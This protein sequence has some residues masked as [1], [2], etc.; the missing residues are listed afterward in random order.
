MPV[1][2][3][4]KP[5]LT[6]KLIGFSDAE[7][8]KFE[9]ILTLAE[10]KLNTPWKLT[11]ATEP[12]FYLISNNLRPQINKDNFLESLPRQQCIFYTGNK[13]DSQ[14]Y[15]IL[16]G[17]DNI[18][19]L[20]SLVEVLNSISSSN[21]QQNEISP[22]YSEI[23]DQ[24]SQKS[25]QQAESNYF[26]PEQGFIGLLLSKHEHIQEYKLIDSVSV[27]KL[28]VDSKNNN[29]YCKYTLGDLEP[30]FAEKKYI[31]K[32]NISAQQLQEIISSE[33]L[34]SNPLNNLLWHGTFIS[35]KGRL[36][37]GHNETA[38]V[39]LK[40]WPDMNMPGSRKLI[41]LAAFMQS[42]S[43]DIN[44]IQQKT[45]IPID[46][47]YNFFNACKIIHLIEYCETT[48]LHKKTLDDNQRQLYAMIEKRLN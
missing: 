8:I 44:T 3:L 36:I 38:I 33:N 7:R 35:S 25:A 20:R 17:S 13:T 29:Y 24:D 4:G 41:K 23:L 10:S 40:R 15:E 12:D 46:Q 48:D 28:Y 16:V 34:K 31:I 37:K 39:R 11:T 5:F 47:I 27:S 32:R 45:N 21:H 9:S 22:S 42:N 30:F 1:N 6:I 18:P 2:L 26:D 14:D 43:A 19:H